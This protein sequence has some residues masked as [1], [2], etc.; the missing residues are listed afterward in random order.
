[1]LSHE[2]YESGYKKEEEWTDSFLNIDSVYNMVQLFGNREPEE[3][4]MRR[5]DGFRLGFVPISVHLAS[6]LEEYGGKWASEWRRSMIEGSPSSGKI[7]IPLE[8][9]ADE[10]LFLI[11]P[12]LIEKDE[13]NFRIEKGVSQKLT[14]KDVY[15][16][17]I[18]LIERYI[19]DRSIRS[20][21]SGEWK[22][23]REEAI[24]RITR[25]YSEV[26]FFLLRSMN[27]SQIE[28]LKE[29]L[30][31]AEI[32]ERNRKY[33]DAIRDAGEV[34]ER[35]L[36]LVFGQENGWKQLSDLRNKIWDD[37]S[38]GVFE[39]LKIIKK[40]RNKYS[41][42]GSEEPKSYECYEVLS[43]A[44]TILGVFLEKSGTSQLF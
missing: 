43:N 18:E 30:L 15:L 12:R 39:N 16:S 10:A 2:G 32:K 33:K 44:R 24:K 21:V 7:M 41:H 37:F 38:Q 19:P 13:E 22:N 40:L 4:V 25:E 28:K 34:A 9:R 42:A 5:K 3:I 17:P 31:Q 26:R 27:K 11:D 8:P 35:L 6:N 14:G 23:I 36:K 1:V 29:K 20:K